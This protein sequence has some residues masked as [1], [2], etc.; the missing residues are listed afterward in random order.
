MTMR[1]LYVDNR[2]RNWVCLSII[3]VR[4]FDCDHSYLELI[5]FEDVVFS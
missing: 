1:S 2:S 5:G 3:V 4:W